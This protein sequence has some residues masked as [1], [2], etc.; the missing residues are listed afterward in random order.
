MSADRFKDIEKGG[1]IEQSTRV[2]LVLKLSQKYEMTPNTNFK[3]TQNEWDMKAEKYKEN[4]CLKTKKNT[5]PTF[6]IFL[7]PILGKSSNSKVNP[8]LLK[9]C[10]PWCDRNSCLHPS[11]RWLQYFMSLVRG[12]KRSQKNLKSVSHSARTK[13]YAPKT[14][15]CHQRTYGRLLLLLLWKC[16]HL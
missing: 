3:L 10:T 9:E 2:N 12:I 13:K 16:M 1:S 4:N 8:W 7:T 6:W 14:L 15:K 11:E 5:N